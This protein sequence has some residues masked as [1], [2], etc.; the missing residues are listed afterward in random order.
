MPSIS[1]HNI[2][3][4]VVPPICHNENPQMLTKVAFGRDR[5][6]NPRPGVDI[7]FL[8]FQYAFFF[9]HDALR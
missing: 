1:K 7:A 4:G 2:S 6:S 5:A 8:L 9:I 3:D